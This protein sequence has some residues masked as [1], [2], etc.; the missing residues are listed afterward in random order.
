MPPIFLQEL[1]RTIVFS[2]CLELPDRDVPLLLQVV[3]LRL[4]RRGPVVIVGGQ[5]QPDKVY[6]DSQSVKHLTIL[7]C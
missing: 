2:S 7:Q 4:Y 6:A 5:A 1:C 3:H